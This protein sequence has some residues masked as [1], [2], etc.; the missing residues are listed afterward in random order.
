VITHQSHPGPTSE[1][2]SRTFPNIKFHVEW[3]DLPL[4][5][6]LPADQMCG[7][8]LYAPLKIATLHSILLS[9]MRK[10]QLHSGRPY[11]E[12]P[13]DRDI[14]AITIHRSTTLL[15]SRGLSLDKRYRIRCSTF[16]SVGIEN[17]SW[18]QQTSLDTQKHLL[19]LVSPEPAIMTGLPARAESQPRI[20]TFEIRF[21]NMNPFHLCKWL[22]FVSCSEMRRISI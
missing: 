7:L 13:D 3:R 10:P 18:S 5:T 4:Q 17:G 1:T 6:A 15:Q 21:L 9:T 19:S 11:V 12:L 8:H 2:I 22:Q 20:K 16:L 14:D